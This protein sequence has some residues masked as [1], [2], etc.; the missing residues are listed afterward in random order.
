[1]CCACGGGFLEGTTAVS[2]ATPRVEKTPT[3]TNTDADGACAVTKTCQ[4][5]VR[6]TKMTQLTQ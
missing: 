3:F 5:D 2:T 4:E 6:A 1:M